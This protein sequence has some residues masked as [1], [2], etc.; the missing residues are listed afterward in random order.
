MKNGKKIL[1]VALATSLCVCAFTANGS[2]TDDVVYSVFVATGWQ[3]HNEVAICA[4]EKKKAVALE[5]GGVPQIIPDFTRGKWMTRP[6]L[7]V[8][9]F[10]LEL[11]ES[12]GKN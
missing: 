2:K 12:E 7:D 8:I 10:E 11:K 6:R 3:T 1:S 4:M 9:D 5:V